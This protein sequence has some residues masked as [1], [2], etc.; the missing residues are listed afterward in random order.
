MDR[1]EMVDV[2]QKCYEQ[3]KCTRPRGVPDR[4]SAERLRRNRC[5]SAQHQWSKKPYDSFITVMDESGIALLAGNYRMQGVI[6]SLF[7]K[8]SY[9]FYH[10][11]TSYRSCDGLI[12]VVSFPDR[13]FPFIFVVHGGKSSLE[14]RMYNACM[15]HLKNVPAIQQ[16]LSHSYITTHNE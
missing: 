4:G 9:T 2:C 6:D 16:I 13:F 1:L 3:Q 15:G 10:I 5:H 14:T 12:N 7:I 8:V 11:A